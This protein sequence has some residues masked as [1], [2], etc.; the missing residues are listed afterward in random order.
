M[1]SAILNFIDWA[2]NQPLLVLTHP[3]ILLMLTALIA[4]IACV[5][6]IIPYIWVCSLQRK[7]KHLQLK[8]QMDDEKEDTERIFKRENSAF[9]HAERKK[10]YSEIN[11]WVHQMAQ[12]GICFRWQ[13]ALGESRKIT[14]RMDGSEE[15]MPCDLSFIE[16]GKYLHLEKA[17]YVDGSGRKIALA[18][19]SLAAI[20]SKLYESYFKTI[21]LQNIGFFSMISE[22]AK[23]R[24]VTFSYC[25]ATAQK[26]ERTTA[27]QFSAFCKV[28]AEEIAEKGQSVSGDFET[29]LVTVEEKK[30]EG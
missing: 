13:W 17:S 11:D 21:L 27:E 26:R 30:F 19:K 28:L 4:P 15:N 7:S 5:L 6:V 18:G 9:I 25:A 14:I 22:E 29:L 24:P 8:A 2:A 3:I 20:P 1:I 16:V 10:F 23:I 12:D